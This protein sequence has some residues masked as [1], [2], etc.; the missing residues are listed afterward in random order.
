MTETGE[1][2]EESVAYESIDP[3]A[4]FDSEELATHYE[5]LMDIQNYIQTV[6]KDVENP[7]VWENA[8]ELLRKDPF[9]YFHVGRSPR[10]DLELAL[11]DERKQLGEYSKTHFDRL[12]GEIESKDFAELIN[13]VPLYKNG[14]SR[15]DEFVEAITNYREMVQ[16]AKDPNKVLTFVK[17]KVLESKN[18][19][20]QTSFMRYGER[21]SGELFKLYFARAKAKLD[22]VTPESESQDGFLKSVFK[23]SLAKAEDKDAEMYYLAL[24]EAVYQKKKAK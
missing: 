16:T 18:P 19:L 12:V 20:L 2:L 22:A 6:Q 13:H 1:P 14:E 21:D 17:K 24:L 7:T 10:S 8:G 3:K 9:Y 11:T 23:N 15:H 4:G 5:G